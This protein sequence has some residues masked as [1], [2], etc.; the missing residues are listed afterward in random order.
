MGQ[1]ESTRHKSYKNINY[2][3]AGGGLKHV[4]EDDEVYA[5]IEAPPS[6][7]LFSCFLFLF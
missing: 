7:G 4:A 5:D 1:L 6:R 3:I 2:A